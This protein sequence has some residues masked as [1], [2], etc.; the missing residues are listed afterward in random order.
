M[1]KAESVT[2]YDDEFEDLYRKMSQI[3]LNTE[4]IL[5]QLDNMIQPNPGKWQG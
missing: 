4:K 3:K 2:V 1:G 5:T